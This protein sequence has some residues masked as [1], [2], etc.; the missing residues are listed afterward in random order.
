M[1]KRTRLRLHNFR[2][3]MMKYVFNGRYMVRN[4]LALT[5]V[6]ALAAAIGGV[7][8]LAGGGKAEEASEE[9][10]QAEYASDEAGDNEYAIN[11]TDR[12]AMNPDSA[13]TL[14]AE[15]DTDAQTAVQPNSTQVVASSRKDIFVVA[16][17][18]GIFVR[19][20]ASAESE[21]IG[22]LCMNDSGY[23][24]SE[25]GDWLYI[26]LYDI[27]G[28]VRS[29][30]V[31]TGSEAEDYIA[32]NTV[33]ADTEVASVSSESN[34]KRSTAASEE[35]VTESMVTESTTAAPAT[36]TA[37]AA[38]VTE[39]TANN[40]TTVQTTSR[41]AISLSDADINLMASVMTLE[42]G[43]ESYEGQLAVA[44]VIINRYLSGA[45]GSTMTDVCYAA[46][47]FSVVG[48]S[49][50]NYYVQNGAQ[51]SCLQAARDALAGNNNIGGYTQFR[52]LSNINT[53]SLSSYTIIGNHVFF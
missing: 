42:C 20:E 12:V 23:V 8:V 15:I 25:S 44:N 11:M 53:D 41:S 52:P 10:A 3:Y 17:E 50:F 6:A 5:I 28:Y 22:S 45:Y 49:S 34:E 2:I 19:S 26:N 38:T 33:T 48:T 36:T 21:I 30:L 13:I 35:P 29:D 51:A 47:Q 40:S 1:S 31:L 27:T 46:N 7:A 4:I 18:E 39:S 32:A 16:I 9:K 14:A 43:G 24:L 37:P